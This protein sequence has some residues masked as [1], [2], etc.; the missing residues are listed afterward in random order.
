MSRSPSKRWVRCRRYCM[1]E[2][3]SGCRRAHPSTCKC[4]SGV[5][6]TAL[7][8]SLRPTA[9]AATKRG[10]V[11]LCASTPT[12]TMCPLP[13]FTRTLGTPSRSGARLC[14]GVVRLLG[15]YPALALRM[16]GGRHDVQQP[17]PQPGPGLMAGTTR[18]RHHSQPHLRPSVL[19]IHPW[20]AIMIT[21][22]QPRASCRL[23][24]P[25]PALPGSPARSTS[26]TSGASGAAGQQAGITE[27]I[28]GSQRWWTLC[29]RPHRPRPV[30]SFSTWVVAL[31]SS[32]S[33][34]HA[35]P[36]E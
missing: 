9:S 15:S 14:R 11:H 12:T 2:R 27:T 13:L 19:A 24:E 21:A 17:R 31:G 20:N 5:A 30:A 4:P 35:K 1:A 25:V 23:W 10:W 22:V 6:A 29:L 32:L 7:S 28:L 3:R 16:T 34:L 8:A 18:S 26:R 33:R 36:R